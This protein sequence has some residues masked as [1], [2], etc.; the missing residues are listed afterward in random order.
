MPAHKESFGIVLIKPNSDRRRKSNP[1]AKSSTFIFTDT[2][3]LSEHIKEFV[4]CDEKQSLPWSTQ[5]PHLPVKAAAHHPAPVNKE[6][7][8]CKQ[9]HHGHRIIEETQDEDGVDAIRCTT[10]KEK[11]IGRNL[12]KHNQIRI[13]V[14]I[15]L[16]MT[17][18]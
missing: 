4:T 14:P 3:K 18:T 7:Y 9:Q 17:D 1:G 12:E 8:S 6:I 10:H 5:K 11:H 2:A 15:T 13:P 16:C